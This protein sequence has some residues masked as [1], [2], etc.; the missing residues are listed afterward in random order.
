MAKYLFCTV[1]YLAVRT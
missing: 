1:L